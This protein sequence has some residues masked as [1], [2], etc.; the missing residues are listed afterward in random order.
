MFL[1]DWYNPASLINT[2][3]GLTAV[4]SSAQ[5][6]AYHHMHNQVMMKC[7]ENVVTSS[8]FIIINL[9]NTKKRITLQLISVFYLMLCT[10]VI[11]V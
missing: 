10:S 11:K 2:T 7:L 3:L 4:D 6:T 5:V 1:K 8:C 9:R